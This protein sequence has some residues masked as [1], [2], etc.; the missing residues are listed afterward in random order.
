MTRRLRFTGTD[1]KNGGCPA[2]H[3]DLDSR[4]I[5]VQGTPFTDPD[6]VAQLKYFGAGDVAVVVPRQLLV[7]WAP[8]EME[9][10]PQMISPEEF[11]RLFETFEHTAWHLETRSGY[12]SD[13]EDLDFGAFLRTGKVTW[14]LDSTWNQN[15]R[16]QVDQGKRVGR[17]RV[18]DDPPTDGQRFLLAY[19]AVNVAAGEDVGCLWRSE[20]QRIG[21]LE[22]DFW[23]FDSR[24]V[25]IL[26][27]DD[28][29]VLTSIETITEP[30]EVVRYSMA[31]DAAVHHAIPYADFVDQASTTE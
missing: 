21:P 19:G 24:L 15:I 11:G 12:A 9:R 18:L 5:I 8:K 14:D 2:L 26:H 13:R 27:F 30:A 23:I 6:G 1:S 20:A 4:E 3:E 17:V 25:A 22:E 7:N 16:G 31:R 29:D 28:T 10:V